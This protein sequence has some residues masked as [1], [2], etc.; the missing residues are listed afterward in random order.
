MFMFSCRPQI[1]LDVK[2]DTETPSSSQ[3]KGQLKTSLF[4]EYYTVSQKNCAT[5]ILLLLWQMLVDF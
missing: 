4:G 1:K 3:S 2:E 5:F